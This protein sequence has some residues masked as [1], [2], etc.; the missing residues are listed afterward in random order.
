MP[1]RLNS[2]AL[3]HHLQHMDQIPGLLTETLVELSERTRQFRKSLIATAVLVDASVTTCNEWPSVVTDYVGPQLNHISGK[4]LD[5]QVRDLDALDNF[6][7]RMCIVG[8]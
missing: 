6:Y 7:L 3:F 8:L 2:S 5:H 4:F 1:L